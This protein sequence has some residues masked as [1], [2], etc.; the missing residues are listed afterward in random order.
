MGVDKKTY[1]HQADNFSQTQPL[2]GNRKRGTEIT[3]VSHLEFTKLRA[4]RW[5]L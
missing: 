2:P 3:E 1:T 5:E 4:N